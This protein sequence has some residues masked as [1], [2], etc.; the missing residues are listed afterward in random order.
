AFALVDPQAN[1]V[2]A[3]ALLA[4][5]CLTCSTF[6]AFAIVAAKRNLTTE[7]HGRKSFF[8]S[9]GVVEG[10]ETIAFFLLMTLKPDWFVPLAWM[11]VAGCVITAVQR[12]LLAL[13]LFRT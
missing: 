12:S 7:T 13:R 11:F 4:S 3:A 8:Y 10:T 2:P 9:R 5:F 1:A 6:L